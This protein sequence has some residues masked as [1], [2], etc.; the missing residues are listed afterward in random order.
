MKEFISTTFFWIY[1]TWVRIFNS[2]ID[3]LL[4]S[5]LS[6]LLVEFLNTVHDSYWFR[7]HSA[8]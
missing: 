5:K 3:Y 8:A 4:Q 6:S 1:G 2:F 7:K